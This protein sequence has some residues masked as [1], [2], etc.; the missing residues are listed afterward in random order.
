[1]ATSDDSGRDVA[2]HDD[3]AEGACKMGADEM[4]GLDQLRRNEI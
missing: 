1:M 2:S 4:A 3:V